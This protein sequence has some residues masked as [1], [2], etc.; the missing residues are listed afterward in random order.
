MKDPIK[1]SRRT[2]L[3]LPF[4]LAACKGGPAVHQLSGAT[5]GTTY[6]ITAVDHAKSSS[7]A[8][9]RDTV[10]TVL[11]EVNTQMSNWDP[12]SEISRFNRAPA[13]Q[14]IAVSR[15]LA[16]VMQAAQDV[17]D[18]SGGQFDVTLGP[19]IE[20]WG[21]GARN[22]GA[23]QPSDAQILAALEGTGQR[24]QVQV[25]GTNISKKIASTEVYLSAIGKGH[26]VDRVARA[27][28]EKGITDYLVEIGG[29][30]Y[31]AGLNPEGEAWQI[32]IETPDALDRRVQSVVGV[33]NLGMATS[34]DYRNYFEKDGVRYSHILDAK[35]GRPIT[36]TTASATV[37]TD[38]AMLA[39]AWATAMLTLGRERGM[40]I[41]EAHNM[42]VLFVERDLEATDLRF[43]ATPSSRFAQLQA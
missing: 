32:G 18:A 21:F 22:A 36:H 20:L 25:N 15:D 43:V 12:S 16:Q 35:T 24:E 6:S 34:G 38:N 39:D 7:E 17:H 29:D 41:A 33:S 42:A 5:M 26:G 9:L 1:F 10:E 3:F 37:L 4:A 27:L 28:E 14:N 2:V 11:A 8:E 31:T 13:G 23:H 19:V 30:L 40:E